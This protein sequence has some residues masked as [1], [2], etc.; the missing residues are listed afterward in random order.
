[1]PRPLRLKIG[2]KVGELTILREAPKGETGAT[3]FVVSCS[4]GSPERVIR[5][6]ALTRTRCCGKCAQFKCLRI[7]FFGE[8]TVQRIIPGAKHSAAK[9]ECLCSCGR[10]HLV[11]V[12]HLLDGHAK[13]CRKCYMVEFPIGSTVGNW[14]IVGY[15]ESD[16]S[17]T[18]ALCVCKKC[19]SGTQHKVAISSLRKK[20]SQQCKQCRNTEGGL[21]LSNLAKQYRKSLGFHPDESM[22]TKSAQARQAFAPIAKQTKKRDGY[23][24]QL[25]SQVGGVLHSHHVFR[26]CDFPHLLLDPMVVITL[27]E[28]CHTKAHQNYWRG[29]LDPNIQFQLLERLSVIYGTT[30]KEIYERCLLQ[31]K[32]PA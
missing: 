12:T 26:Y 1:M 29:P 31:Q 15:I 4:C 32:E 20:I 8:L 27:C 3:Y 22:S 14:E 28:D 11:A 23:K 17:V 16:N 21:I 10:T 7:K 6:G 5:A 13:S 24:C 19:G 30:L 2:D 25:C 9:A 18:D